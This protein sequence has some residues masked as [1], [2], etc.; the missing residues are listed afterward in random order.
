MNTKQSRRGFCPH[1]GE[2]MDLADCYFCYFK[3]IE[4]LL[5]TQES[6]S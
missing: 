2:V 1:F 3:K 5:H 4:P 6:R